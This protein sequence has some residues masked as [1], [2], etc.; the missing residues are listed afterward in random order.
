MFYC[1]CC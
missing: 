1:W